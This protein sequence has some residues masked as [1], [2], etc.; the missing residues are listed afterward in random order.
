[1]KVLLVEDTKTLSTLV[2]IYLMGWG[3]NFVVA[4]DGMDGLA[5]AQAEKPDLVISDVRMPRMD[6]FEFCAALRADRELGGVPI[7]LLT[8][9]HDEASHARGKEVGAT[10]FLH[11]PIAVDALRNVVARLLNLPEVRK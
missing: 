10:A 4:G 1:M 7:V 3:L 9:L 5:K 8:S 6:G 2:Q 11:K